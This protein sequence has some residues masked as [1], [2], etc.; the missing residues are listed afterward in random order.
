MRFRVLSMVLLAMAIAGCA[1]IQGPIKEVEA[2]GAAIEPFMEE[3]SKTV[4]ADPSEAGVEKAAKLWESKKADLKAK[5]DA[6]DTAPQGKNADWLSLLFKIN[7][8]TKEYLR[9]V[10]TS[11]SG[12]ESP[13][14]LK[15]R[16]LRTDI[17]KTLKLN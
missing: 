9:G 10:E 1:Y 8:R 2:Y 4:A 5:R 12:Y 7:G 16:Q 3:L 14:H 15:F 11:V 17:E 6:I 13:G